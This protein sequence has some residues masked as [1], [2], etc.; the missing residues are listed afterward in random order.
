MLS[1]HLQIE[2]LEDRWLPSG[3]TATQAAGYGQIPLSFELNQG[4]T[5]SQVNFLSRGDGYALFLS[6]GQAVLSLDRSA[7]SAAQDVVTMKLVG[8]N[9]AAPAVGL[10]QQPGI[11]NY[12][13]GNDPSRWR[14]K[15]PNYGQVEYQNIYPGINLIYYG[16]QRQL[17]YDFQVAP[18]ADASRI[19]LAFTGVQG[20][21]VDAQGNLD[22]HTAGGDVI[23]RAPILYQGTGASR[24]S[25]AGQYVLEGTNQVG[26][27]VG[28]YDP[29]QTL[30]I[31]PVLSYSTY[32]GGSGTDSGWNI[33]V[34]SAGDAFL[35][36]T[37]T[38]PNFPVT[39]GTYQPTN[40][41]TTQAFFVTELNPAGSS[42]IYSTYLGGTKGNQIIAGGL[43]LDSAGNVYLT[44]ETTS[45]DFPTTPG[46]FQTTFASDDA[47]VT[48][49]NASGTALVYSTF[50]NGN[51][52]TI[53]EGIAADSA[54]DA[55]VTGESH[56]TN[57][58]TTTGAAQAKFGGGSEDAFVGALNPTGSSLLYLT[59]LGGSGNEDTGEPDSSIAV[60]S[61]GNAYVTGA[62]TSTDFPT[63]TGAFQ[64][65]LTGTLNAFVTKL[66]STGTAFV[67]ST[68]LGGSGS[69]FTEGI[70]VDAAGNAY[71]SGATNSS[72]FPTLNAIQ[73]KN[74]G[75]YDAFVTKLNPT[76]AGLVWSTYLGGSG[77]ENTLSTSSTGI[78]AIA[79]DA[80]DNV[81]V[82]GS[83][84]STDFPL[85]NAVQSTYG[86]GPHDA[87]VAAID[88]SGSKILYSTFLGGLGGDWVNGLAV[89]AAGDAYVTGFGS[90]PFPTTPGAFQ[91]TSGG[92]NDAFVTK[93]SEPITPLQQGLIGYWPF[94][95][96]GTDQSGN[97]RD[98]G[99]AGGVGFAQGLF[100]QALD[101]HDNGK[102]YA[103]RPSD[104]S[105]YDFGSS[106]FT[107]QVWVN[108]NT[109]TG[110]EQTL[111]EKWVGAAGP[112]WTL[113]K[114]SDC[115]I[116]G[117]FRKSLG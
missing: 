36:G 72:D 67:Y 104:D 56:A 64:T 53:G 115:P 22:L 77:D 112:G 82:G 12:F 9:P 40:P 29:S 110:R 111:I 21:S 101:L 32:L 107:V 81:Y 5:D 89:D 88:S 54:G 91:T 83:T 61:S 18:G 6:P 52:Q 76:G 109:T 11:S 37:T 80:A 51:A 30:V 35:Y 116:R 41:S 70:A 85:A 113:T 66:N 75:G 49:L 14:A 27:R 19:Q 73:P 59:Y 17:E 47:F 55:Y 102:Q 86:G 8:A 34:D 24:R 99:L 7:G 13:I 97:G 74:A 68:Y 92:G 42:L 78:G 84:A 50:L 3:V 108:F 103:A 4:Q 106:D 16:N 96:N 90:S 45:S 44:G 23:E 48:K 87:F 46:A 15:V 79:L 58:P 38:S 95:G 2:S 28:S 100:G 93:L 94:N 33:A 63:T 26:F 20:M 71:V 65:K 57:L 62:T 43:A 60:D 69:D 10:E 114:L 105:V 39:T 25:I 117:D 1:R 98:L 31:D